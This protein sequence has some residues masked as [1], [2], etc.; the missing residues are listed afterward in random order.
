MSKLRIK[1][2]GCMRFMTGAQTFCTIRS[3]SESPCP[4][5]ARALCGSAVR[6]YVSPEDLS[7]A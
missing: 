3:A 1:V 6:G 7:A 5:A 2:S 4:R